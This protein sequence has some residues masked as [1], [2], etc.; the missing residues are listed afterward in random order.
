MEFFQKRG[1]LEVS[2]STSMML[3]QW[4]V[5][6][7]VYLKSSLANMDFLMFSV[8]SNYMVIASGLVAYGF[9]ERVVNDESFPSKYI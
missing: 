9:L 7:S 6:S 5:E 2:V 4:R 1:M 3:L 8:I